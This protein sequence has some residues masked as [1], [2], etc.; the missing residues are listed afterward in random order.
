MKAGQYGLDMKRTDALCPWSPS[1][2]VALFIKDRWPF[3]SSS[4]H[5]PTPV[6][7][8]VGVKD[9]L[10]RSLALIWTSPERSAFSRSVD[11]LALRPCR[12]DLLFI[13][14]SMPV[15]LLSWKRVFWRRWFCPDVMHSDAN[16]CHATSV[17]E[18]VCVSYVFGICLN[19]ITLSSHHNAISGSSWN[20]SALFMSFFSAS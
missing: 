1:Y 20:H 15:I 17:S 3:L 9:A 13:I 16:V 14:C 8:L 6:C 2:D 11:S 5:H 18:M 7:A 19:Y 10:W 4:G 12:I